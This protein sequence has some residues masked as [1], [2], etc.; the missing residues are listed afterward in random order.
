[1][2]SLDAPD[3]GVKGMILA[4]PAKSGSIGS[5]DCTPDETT[6]LHW[7]RAAVRLAGA[8]KRGFSDCLR[9]IWNS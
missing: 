1:M 9:L 4:D 6:T 2:P 8:E 7:T 3:E 5:I